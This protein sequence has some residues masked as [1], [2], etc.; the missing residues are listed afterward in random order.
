MVWHGFVLC[1]SLYASIY[2]QYFAKILSEKD[3][4]LF[5]YFYFIIILPFK[6]LYIKLKKYHAREAMEANKTC[7]KDQI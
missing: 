7:E 2:I 1:P 3:K 4:F 5:I 6:L